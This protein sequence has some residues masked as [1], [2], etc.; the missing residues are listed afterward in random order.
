MSVRPVHP[1]SRDETDLQRS[2]VEPT[3][4]VACPCGQVLTGERASAFQ[5]RICDR[6]GTAHGILASNPR[7]RPL[8][9]APG[10]TSDSTA[11]SP[12]PD[13]RSRRRQRPAR[14]RL[15][16]TILFVGGALLLLLGVV[17]ASWQHRVAQRAQVDLAVGL[18]EGK[19]ALRAVDLDAALEHLARASSAAQLIPEDSPGTRMAHQLY[20]EVEAWQSQVVFSLFDLVE[21]IERAQ[22]EEFVELRERFRTRFGGRTIL[23]DTVLTRQAADAKTNNVSTGKAPD[24]IWAEWQLESEHTSLELALHDQPLL[25]KYLSPDEPARVLFGV[26]LADLVPADSDVSAWRLQL[27]PQS[28]VFLTSP[29][30]LQYAHWPIDEELAS[31]LDRQRK[32]LEIEP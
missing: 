18:R 10:K 1:H 23:V 6:C 25:L 5:P 13:I 12:L 26:R 30:P 27:T 29:E 28:A 22:P 8:P 7:P 32:F 15:P 16:R 19:A 9:P 11:L 4:R 24:L 14:R 31:V 3:Y 17:F 2:D 20:R 21:E